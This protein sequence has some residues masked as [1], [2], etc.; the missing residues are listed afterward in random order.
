M[1]KYEPDKTP[2]E[3]LLDASKRAVE[4]YEAY[5]LDK[6]GWRELAQTMTALRKKIAAW[7]SKMKS[8]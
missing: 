3:E 7:E 4:D 2:T 6:V 8:R 5:L 1:S